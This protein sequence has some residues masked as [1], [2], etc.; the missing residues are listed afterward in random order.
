MLWTADCRSGSA[1]AQEE[2]AGKAFLWGAAAFVVSQLLIRIPILQL[3]LPN[4]WVV[5]GNAAIS[6][7]VRTVSGTDGRTG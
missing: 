7:D 3:V 4:F 2:G 6:L 5:C 1:D